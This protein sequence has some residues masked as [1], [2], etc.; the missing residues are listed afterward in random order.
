[1]VSASTDTNNLLKPELALQ[2]WGPKYSDVD[3]PEGFD[4]TK[5]YE[6][7][8]Y[9]TF[10]HINDTDCPAF[11][12]SSKK[13]YTQPFI[14]NEKW[15]Y[16][17]NIGGCAKDC[18]CPPCS[19]GAEMRCSD[20]H[21]DHPEMFHPNE[22]ISHHRRLL[23][24]SKMQRPIFNRPLSDPKSCPPKLELAGIKKKC[25]ICRTN[26][27]NHLKYHHTL[28]SDVCE[29]CYHKE[30]ISKNS[31]ELICYV[32]MK[33]FESKYRLEDHM[34]THDP[35]NNP[36]TC[37][38]C[39]KGFTTKYVYE[40]HVMENHKDND[41]IFP[42]TECE[43]SYTLER[44]LLRHIDTKHTAKLKHIC[45]ICEE[46]FERKDVLRQHQK[47]VHQIETRKVILPGINEGGNQFECYICEKMFKEKYKL[48]RHLE[49]VHNNNCDKYQC[50]TCGK[51]FKRKDY[52]QKH[53]KIHIKIICEICLK[54][55]ES[56][57]G[58][59]AHRIGNHM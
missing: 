36:Y 5:N 27:K 14:R 19:D 18:E 39:D 8:R 17:C 43:K 57:D 55:F 10:Q 48:N 46:H 20:H 29:I 33:K 53:S 4:Q 21:P 54:H 9:S 1:M 24:D 51:Q 44:N 22:D 30:F 47:F 56:K 41:Q 50:Q 2:M 31:F 28:H 42:C 16:P 12:D 58:L 52:L 32:C 15:H 45:N 38:I 13:I 26:F 40:R 35:E 3:I 6:E 25:R 59:K 11:S 7:C 23:F 37:K 34:N 49:T